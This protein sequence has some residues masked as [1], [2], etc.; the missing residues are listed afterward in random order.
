MKNFILRKPKFMRND[1][2]MMHY[3]RMIEALE[4]QGGE[5]RTIEETIHLLETL[6]ELMGKAAK[7][8]GFFTKKGLWRY[9]VKQATT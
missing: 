1:E 4:E 7:A 5:S 9:M 8:G 3:L 2:E 6:D